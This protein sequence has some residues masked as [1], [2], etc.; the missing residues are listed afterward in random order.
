MSGS[1][2]DRFCKMEKPDF[3]GRA[4]L[5]QSK[6]GGQRRMLVGL[7]MMERGIARDDYRCKTCPEK[8]DT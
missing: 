3:I 7:E 2:L 6:S 5:E 1:S 8:L 4:A